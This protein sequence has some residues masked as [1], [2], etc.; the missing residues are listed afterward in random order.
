MTQLVGLIRA[1]ESLKG[2]EPTQERQKNE[3]KSPYA[4]FSGYFSSADKNPVALTNRTFLYSEISFRAIAVN[5][6][7]EPL[8]VQSS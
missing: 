6:L 8:C 7:S 1:V 5:M 2:T 4:K 3:K